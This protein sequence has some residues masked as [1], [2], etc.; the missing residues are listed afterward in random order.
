MNQFPVKHPDEFFAFEI[1]F[2]KYSQSITSASVTASVYLGE[3]A[4]PSGLLS[5]A[6]QISGSKVSQQVQAG[7]DGTTYLLKIT[8][9]DGADIW[10]YEVLLP[11]AKEQ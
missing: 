3:D 8:A 11:V 5:G 7:V 6:A 4:A 1:D 9:S 10:V 2:T